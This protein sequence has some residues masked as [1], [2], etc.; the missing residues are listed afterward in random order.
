MTP[1]LHRTITVRLSDSSNPDLT[2]VARCVDP[3]ITQMDAWRKRAKDDITPL[4]VI[5]S[6]EA[7]DSAEDTSLAFDSVEDIPFR[8]AQAII[9][10]WAGR[11]IDTGA[12]TVA[13]K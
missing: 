7:F 6:C 9:N 2:Y 13:G 4:E 8:L 10:E 1:T 3:T 12:Y 5:Y 11:I